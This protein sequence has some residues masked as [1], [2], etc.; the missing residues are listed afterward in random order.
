MWP[1]RADVGCE[2]NRQ[3][4]HGAIGE[5]DAGT[6]QQGVLVNGRS[7]LNVVADVRNMDL[8]RE[9]AIGPLFDPDGIVEI[10]RGL[11]VDGDNIQMA[12]VAAP[13]ELG[14]IDVVRNAP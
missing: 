9:M 4:G 13:T 2:L 7:G 14:W 12:E 1:Q 10:A 5:V 6:A 3:H 8:Q 11:A